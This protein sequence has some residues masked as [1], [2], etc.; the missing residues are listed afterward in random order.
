MQTA[1]LKKVWAVYPGGFLTGLVLVLFPASGSILISAE[2]HGFSTGQF[3]SIF[4]P[5][6]I[7]AIAASLLASKLADKIGMKKVMLLGLMA[8]VFSSGLLTLSHWFAFNTAAAYPM[9]MTAT[10]FLGIGFGFT[11]TALNPFAYQLFPGKEASALTALHFFLGAGTA[12]SPLLISFFDSKD[13]WW[14]GP[15]VSMILVL[16]LLI[17]AVTLPLKLNDENKPKDTPTLKFTIP[18][19]L[20]LYIIGVFFYGACEGTFGSWGQV[21]LE[22]QGGLSIAQA[23]LGLSLFWG[24]VALGRIAFTLLALR[25]KTDWLFVFAPWLVAVIFYL[26]PYAQSEV[27]Y[28][29]AMSLGGLFTSFLF[30]KSV[31]NSTDEF[32][33]QSAL[34]SGFM[35]AALQ[36]GT[37][38][39][40]NFIGYLSESYSLGTLFK[41]SLVYAVIFGS[42]VFYLVRSQNKNREFK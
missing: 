6:I 3:G 37:G 5:Q 1:T 16:L 21:F 20:W 8:L 23:S 36:L 34:I 9:V 31:S 10:G 2:H 33:A 19:R 26:T 41:F 7:L 11:L 22:K 38:F 32:P 30:P 42:I 39:S 13:I 12:T 28:L 25:I 14:M 40:A 18:K 35:V 15:L 24:F 29:A 4:T 27:T 17:Y